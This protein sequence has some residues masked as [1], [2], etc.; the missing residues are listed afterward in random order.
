MSVPMKDR[1]LLTPK[2]KERLKNPPNNPNIRKRNNLI[3]KAKIGRWLN[4]AK[5]IY[6]ALDHLKDTKIEGVFLDEDIFVLF[7]T[8]EKL[9]ERMH[10][11]PVLGEPQYP[12][13][14]YTTIATEKDAMKQKEIQPGIVLE[15]WRR[16]TPSDLE[17]DYQVQEFAK[18]LSQYYPD[19]L[20]ESPAYKLYIE[21]KR[22]KLTPKEA[23]NKVIQTLGKD[24]WCKKEDETR[25]IE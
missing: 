20:N 18:N 23:K 3:V 2:E 16:A 5:D 10:F 22:R 4:E 1:S 8:I 21:K 17:R 12:I 25:D 15:W 7:I 13:L 14:P 9:L 11:G 19:D 24:P 6:F